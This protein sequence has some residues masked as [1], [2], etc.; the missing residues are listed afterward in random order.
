MPKKRA[1]GQAE[2]SQRPCLRGHGGQVAPP[3]Q[4]LPA[5]SRI[6]TRTRLAT[7]LDDPTLRVAPPRQHPRPA[8]PR[9]RRGVTGPFVPGGL[10]P[11]NPVAVAAPA[12]GR[13]ALG[14]FIPA[15]GYGAAATGELRA[16]LVPAPTLPYLRWEMAGLPGGGGEELTL[17]ARDAHT[18]ATTRLDSRRLAGD[19]WRVEHLARPGPPG[20][21]VEVVAADRTPTGWLAFREPTEEGALSFWAGW[22]A[23]R[24]VWV[25]AAGGGCAVL[26]SGAAAW[27]ALRRRRGAGGRHVEGVV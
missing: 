27:S 10:P 20:D 21:A 13:P 1:W 16:A 3:E 17:G 18:G 14:S 2:E 4:A 9:P 11:G 7:L 24:G 15:D 25:L 12:P 23:R 22:L 5:T 26:A 6:L 19:H 8:A